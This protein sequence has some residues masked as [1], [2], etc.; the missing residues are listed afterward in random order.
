MVTDHPL[1]SA[2]HLRGFNEI[3]YLPKEVNIK[4]NC[5]GGHCSQASVRGCSM[6]LGV[7][8]GENYDSR[9]RADGPSRES[10]GRASSQLAVVPEASLPSWG[11]VGLGHGQLRRA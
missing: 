4:E 5:S 3:C 6:G 7:S 11:L 1:L 2:Q 8:H 9:G 10:Q